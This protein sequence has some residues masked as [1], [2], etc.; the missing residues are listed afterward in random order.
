MFALLEFRKL[1]LNRANFVI[2]DEYIFFGSR[3]ETDLEH[4]WTLAEKQV[5]AGY[6]N[7]S[8]LTQDKQGATSSSL[9]AKRDTMAWK[10]MLGMESSGEEK[11]DQELEVAKEEGAMTEV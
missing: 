4:R 6:I 2:S 9:G 1:S 7:E 5:W 3:A 8:I 10:V 11:G